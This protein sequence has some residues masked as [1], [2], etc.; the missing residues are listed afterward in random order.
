M[1]LPVGCRWRCFLVCQGFGLAHVEKVAA[2]VDLLIYTRSDR[3]V[4]WNNTLYLTPSSPRH[5]TGIDHFSTHR[6]LSIAHLFP[7]PPFFH[8]DILPLHNCNGF[9]PDPALILFLFKTFSLLSW[10]V[11]YYPWP[12]RLNKCNLLFSSMDKGKMAGESCSQ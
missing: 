11:F 5:P 9:E 6:I 10:T 8:P 1:N 2:Q 7:P 3:D 4:N 12:H